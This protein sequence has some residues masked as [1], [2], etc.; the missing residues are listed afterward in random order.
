MGFAHEPAGSNDL[1]VA[2]KVVLGLIL[3][4]AAFGPFVY[5]AI[6]REVRSEEYAAWDQMVACHDR[7]ES[8]AGGVVSFFYGKWN[9]SQRWR[10]GEF[11]PVPREWK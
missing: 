2:Q 4:A 6:D 5:M 9:C 7:V 8:Q 1:S 3:S 10:A 11:G